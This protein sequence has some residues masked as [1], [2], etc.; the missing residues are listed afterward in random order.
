MTTPPVAADDCRFCLD[1]YTPAGIHRQLG[2]IYTRCLICMTW[3]DIPTCQGCQGRAVFPA[4]THCLPCL[5]EH[6]ATRQLL[7]VLCEGCLGV[8]ALIPTTDQ[9]DTP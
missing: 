8:L 5:L 6:L 1:G 4:T 9:E 7:P 3:G 2:P